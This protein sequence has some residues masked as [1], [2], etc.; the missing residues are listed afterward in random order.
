MCRPFKSQPADHRKRM[1]RHLVAAP[2]R[3]ILAGQPCHAAATAVRREFGL[4]GAQVALGHAAADVTQ[5]YAERDAELAR[6]VAM[7]IG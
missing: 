5:I 1:T 7:A 3:P 6:R 4:E 2:T